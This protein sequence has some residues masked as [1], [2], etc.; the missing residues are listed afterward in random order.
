[1][2]LATIFVVVAS[3]IVLLSLMVFFLAR[4]RTTDKVPAILQKT[5]FP[6]SGPTPGFLYTWHKATG[7]DD[8]G[9][10]DTGHN[11]SRHGVA[12]YDASRHDASS[13]DAS[14]YDTSRHD[15]NE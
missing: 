9:H 10:D 13:Y 12:R 1:M 15:V 8:T 11:V 14:R 6:L 3:W 7:H 2:L 4:K 5:M